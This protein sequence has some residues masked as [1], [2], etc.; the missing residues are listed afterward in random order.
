MLRASQNLE[1]RESTGTVI[2][3][4]VYHVQVESK[5]GVHSVDRKSDHC[6]CRA[7]RTQSLLNEI[8]VI[9]IAR[10][11]SAPSPESFLVE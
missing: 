5:L 3:V 11:H 10:Q 8:F 6:H 4:I 2:T 9:A 1:C 7:V